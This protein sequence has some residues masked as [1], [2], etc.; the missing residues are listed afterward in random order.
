MGDAGRAHGP[1]GKQ[2]P[3]ERRGVLTGLRLDMADLNLHEFND[4][5]NAYDKE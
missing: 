5:V 2:L 3:K 4:R 1:G